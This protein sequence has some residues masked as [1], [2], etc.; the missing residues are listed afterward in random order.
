MQPANP[1]LGHFVMTLPDDCVLDNEHRRH[2]V[3]TLP[4]E[5]VL[6][7]KTGDILS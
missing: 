7:N 1:Y 6:D 3:M 5:H 2:F 4:D